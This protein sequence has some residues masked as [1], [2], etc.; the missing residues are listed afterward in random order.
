VS[1]RLFVAIEIDPPTRSAVADVILR[2]QKRLRADVKWV[3]PENLHITLQFIGHVEE[4]VAAR[5]VAALSPPIGVPPFAMRVAGLGAFPPH[6]GP[7]VI[8]CRTEAPH[9]AMTALHAEVVRRMHE[10][11]RIEPESRPFQAH[12]TIGRYRTAG[13]AADR[14]ALEGI[15]AG[16]LGIV[17][18]DRVTLFESRLSPRGPT[19]APLAWT[20]LSGTIARS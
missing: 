8:W 10:A 16:V 7:R 12:L 9:A 6:G 11:A 5:I 1:L 4:T 3:V 13:R 18:V 20:A 17:Q 14:R 19:Y 15:E 2:V